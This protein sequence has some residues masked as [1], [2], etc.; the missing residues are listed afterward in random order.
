MKIIDK[1]PA[2]ISENVFYGVNIQDKQAV[3]REFLRLR[4]KHRNIT[5]ITVILLAI[6]GVFIVDFCR[7]KAIVFNINFIKRVFY[8]YGSDP[9]IRRG[10][11]ANLE[12]E[13]VLI[14]VSGKSK[15]RISDGVDEIIVETEIN[16]L[17]VFN[18][19]LVEILLV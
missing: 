18:F 7:Y 14:N 12:S 8:I 19:K 4:K 5:I 10:Q 16:I 17:V 9:D 2:E 15:V 11:H 6:I 13:F 3:E 1:K